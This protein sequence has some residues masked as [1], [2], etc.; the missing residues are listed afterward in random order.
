MHVQRVWVAVLLAL[1]CFVAVA[2]ALGFAGAHDAPD[3][4][5]IALPMPRVGDEAVY[6]TGQ[7]RFDHR[8]APVPYALTAAHAKW[9]AA[10][11]VLDANGSSHP[12]AV[13]LLQ[14]DYTF[15]DPVYASLTHE[16]IAY[17]LGT[18]DAVSVVS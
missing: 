12:A 2:G 17:D 5:A 9:D 18:R 6:A 10:R 7:V 1:T 11:P 16:A 15:R 3:E 13:L 8:W 4:R 14:A